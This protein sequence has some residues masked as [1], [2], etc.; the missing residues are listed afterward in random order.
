V[1]P[2]YLLRRARRLL[3]WIRRC[4]HR[5]YDVLD[6]YQRQ[7]MGRTVTCELR[8]CRWCGREWTRESSFTFDELA[9]ITQ[10]HYADVFED[11]AYVEND[12]LRRARHHYGVYE[13][14]F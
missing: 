13:P 3:M 5:R 2:G 7:R 8:R 14:P 1:R 4:E 10:T 6:T 9:A 12:V 11:Q